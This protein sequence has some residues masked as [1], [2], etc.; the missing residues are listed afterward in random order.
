MPQLRGNEPILGLN[1]VPLESMFYRHDM[2]TGKLVIDQSNDAFE[3]NLDSKN[4]PRM[5][6]MGK[7]T[8]HVERESIII[9]T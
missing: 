4:D 7:G 2:Y 9:L 5:V 6:K 8:T 1:N 3:F